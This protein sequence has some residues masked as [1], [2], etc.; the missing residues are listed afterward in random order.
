MPSNCRIP[1]A[2]HFSYAAAANSPGESIPGY[3]AVD[4]RI[5]MEGPAYSS[6]AENPAYFSRSKRKTTARSSG[7]R[8]S[9]CWCPTAS[10]R[11]RVR[12]RDRVV[13]PESTAPYVDQGAVSWPAH[14]KYKQI[15]HAGGRSWQCHTHGELSHPNILYEIGPDVQVDVRRSMRSGAS[16]LQFSRLSGHRTIDPRQFHPHFL[17]DSRC[18]ALGRVQIMLGIGA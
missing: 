6:S 10:G 14:R 4:E 16:R 1:S 8:G 9:G 12:S 15:A 2:P 3:P 17:E 18:H 11:S 13:L 5:L 7:P